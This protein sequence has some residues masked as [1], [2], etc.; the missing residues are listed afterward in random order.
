MPTKF[1][2]KS[3]K[4]E[5]R[6]INF[7]TGGAERGGQ[8]SGLRSSVAS[9]IHYRFDPLPPPFSRGFE[10]ILIS[11]RVLILSVEKSFSSPV[12]S[13]RLTQKYRAGLAR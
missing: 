6:A 1:R 7:Y 8:D 11:Q 12:L 4:R 10:N 5:T 9:V 2:K 13:S 3:V